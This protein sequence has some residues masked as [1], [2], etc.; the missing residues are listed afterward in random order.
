MFIAVGLQASSCLHSPPLPP[1]HMYTYTHSPKLQNDQI[2]ELFKNCQ[3]LLMWERMGIDGYGWE[4]NVRER[5]EVWDLSHQ[6]HY[7]CFPRKS[8][9]QA[10]NQPPP[11]HMYTYIHSPKLDDQ[12]AELFKNCQH[13]LMW[14]R[15]GIDV[16]DWEERECVSV[17]EERGLRPK[18]S[19]P[20]QVFSQEST[21]Q[22][23]RI[24]VVISS[25]LLPMTVAVPGDIFRHQQS[26]EVVRSIFTGPIIVHGARLRLS[27]GHPAPSA[28][29]SRRHLMVWISNVTWD[30]AADCVDDDLRPVSM[31]PGSQRTF[32]A[33]S[34]TCFPTV[35]R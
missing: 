29:P 12:I 18:S 2:A 14:E 7:R 8:G 26:R 11:A 35:R 10:Y 31:T 21:R 27:C 30:Y 23:Y 25:S 16:Y 20:L 4:E 17:R 19:E 9:L 6:S 5:R 24:I 33:L 15:M 32:Y 28:P 1:A 34:F 3:H 22:S 13:W